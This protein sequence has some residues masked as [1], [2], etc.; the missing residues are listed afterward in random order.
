[1]Q[2]TS[3]NNKCE[4]VALI[5]LAVS[6]SKNGNEGFYTVEKDRNHLSMSVQKYSPGE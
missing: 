6:T 4:E 2:G 5:Y 1:M 3:K